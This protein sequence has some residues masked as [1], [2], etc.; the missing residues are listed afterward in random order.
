MT[1]TMIHV[2]VL[3]L[4]PGLGLLIIQVALSMTGWSGTR[5]ETALRSQSAPS[6]RSAT[7]QE[8]PATQLWFSNDHRQ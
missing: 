2:A 5:A 8:P 4:V 1:M 7:G 3:R 6:G